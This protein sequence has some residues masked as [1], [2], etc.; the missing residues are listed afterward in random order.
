MT[1]WWTQDW[2]PLLKISSRRA[3]MYTHQAHPFT[4]ANK[5]N[6]AALQ[7]PCDEV[8]QV[9]EYDS[10]FVEAYKGKLRWFYGRAQMDLTN[11]NYVHL[12]MVCYIQSSPFRHLRPWTFT[13]LQNCEIIC[14]H[15]WL[16][17]ITSHISENA[18]WRYMHY[19]A[20][21]GYEWKCTTWV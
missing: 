9:A 20:A 17:E 11:V 16:S 14:G 12:A 7:L 13:R 21:Q 10:R 8:W 4:D 2:E 15:T 18:V 1:L 3:C 6:I 19:S 5:L